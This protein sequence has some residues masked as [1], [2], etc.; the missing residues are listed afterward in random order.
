[1]D[2][3]THSD[4]W[5]RVDKILQ[6]AL[7][8]EPRERA[9]FLEQICANDPSV[10]RQVETLIRSFEA[11][12]NFLDSR[13]RSL[14]GNVFGAYEVK[15][16]VGRGGMGEV[17]AAWDSKLKR[18]VAIKVLPDEFSLNTERVLRISSR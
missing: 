1:V 9:Q 12:G 14:V 7:E 10:K 6:D 18:D 3:E 4:L 11:A 2:D 15:T 17:Y 8:L 16:L 13:V 5:T